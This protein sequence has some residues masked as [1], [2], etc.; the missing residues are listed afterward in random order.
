L[1]K[2][3]ST[4][5]RGCRRQVFKESPHISAMSEIWIEDRGSRDNPKFV[6]VVRLG[7]DSPRARDYL[8]KRGYSLAN[9]R[10]EKGFRYLL[11]AS[12][13]RERV[14]STLRRIGVKVRKRKFALGVLRASSSAGPAGGGAGASQPRAPSPSSTAPS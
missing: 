9:G 4:L 1:R 10:W 13:E 8:E 14:I 5:W 11:D 2:K 7:E 12:Y 6:V 3:R